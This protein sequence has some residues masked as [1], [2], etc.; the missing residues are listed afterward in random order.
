MQPT[1]HR[2]WVPAAVPMAG[3]AFGSSFICLSSR[4][5]MDCWMRLDLVLECAA[6]SEGPKETVLVHPVL[7]E[8][9]YKAGVGAT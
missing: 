6:R 7:Q 4:W 8:K 9:Q 5:R 3:S 2:K 1:A